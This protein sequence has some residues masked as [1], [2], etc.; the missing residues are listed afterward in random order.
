MTSFYARDEPAGT[1]GEILRHIRCHGT[2]CC[3]YCHKKFPYGR[4][5][6][7]TH[8]CWI[9]WKRRKEEPPVK[10]PPVKK[11]EEDEWR[12]EAHR[13]GVPDS[14]WVKPSERSSYGFFPDSYLE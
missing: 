4:E 7:H 11:W 12:H 1:V 9:L 10:T 13:Q 3:F 2:R 14:M 5:K 6:T 8:G